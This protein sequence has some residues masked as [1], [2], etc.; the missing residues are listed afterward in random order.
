MQNQI[1]TEIVSDIQFPQIEYQI[2]KAICY[3][4]KKVSTVI[5]VALE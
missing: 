5:A 3:S 2:Q 4:T 1:L